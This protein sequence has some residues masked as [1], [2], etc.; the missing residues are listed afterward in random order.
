MKWP[1]VV[2]STLEGVFQR[3]TLGRK[4]FCGRV[5]LARGRA[6]SCKFVA[7]FAAASHSI[8]LGISDA[9]SHRPGFIDVHGA[10]GQRRKGRPPRRLRR[11]QRPLKER[12]EIAEPA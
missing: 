12:R 4:A 9:P 7:D 2:W 10:V 11:R 5:L 6:I 8:L 3:A 1:S